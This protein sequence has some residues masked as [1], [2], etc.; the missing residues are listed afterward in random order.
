MRDYALYVHWPWCKKKCPYCDFNSHVSASIPEADYVKAL[1]Y[2]LAFQ[3]EK[4]PFSAKQRRLVSIFFGGGTPSLMSPNSVETIINA[5]SKAFT[6][7]DD[8]EITLEANPTS[9]YANKIKP[10]MQAGINRFS[11][12]VQ[13]LRDKHLEFLGREHSSREALAT[14]DFVATHASNFNFD[15]I[16]G[17][18][19]Q[20]I[21]EWEKDLTQAIAI[22]S[23]HLSCYQLTIEPNTA[24][25]KASR[26]GEF[27]PIDTDT[28]GL[29]MQKTRETCEALKLENYE[30]SNFC[31]PGYACRHNSHIWQ[32]GDYVGIGA[33]AHGRYWQTNNRHYMTRN[34]KMPQKYIEQTKKQQPH[35][36]KTLTTAQERAF[37]AVL[38]GLRLKKGVRPTPES[39]LYLDQDGIKKMTSLGF[40]HA[41]EDSF[42]LTNKGWPL[43]ESITAEIL[44]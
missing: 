11:I 33:G 5:S 13:S 23:T 17:L 6:L 39:Q 22:N 9:T 42:S 34:F 30:I 35:F 29:F 38:L 31:Q 16:Y 8:I 4:L 10:F 14:I 1:A 19:N 26:S 24:F 3:A 32:Y 18:P 7:A 25:F 27:N 44:K 36:E 2:D 37:E 41:K 28:E 15:L 20:Q 40:L 43:L 21:D 12:G